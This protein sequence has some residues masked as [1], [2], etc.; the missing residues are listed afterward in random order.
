MNWSPIAM[1]WNRITGGIRSICGRQYHALAADWLAKI[2][3]KDHYA[4]RRTS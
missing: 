1:W 3:L 2:R 4:E